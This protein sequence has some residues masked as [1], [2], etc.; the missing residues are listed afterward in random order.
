[1][2][3]FEQNPDMFALNKNSHNLIYDHFTPSVLALDQPGY[4]DFFM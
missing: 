4:W 3:F 2:V 1:M